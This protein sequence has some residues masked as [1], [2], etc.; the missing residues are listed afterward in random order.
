MIKKILSAFLS[1]AVIAA[2]I[3]AYVVTRPEQEYYTV[4]A[5][6]E[7]APNLFAGGRVMVRG[8]EVG[9]ITDVTPRP[10]GVRVTMKIEEGTKLPADAHLA[11]VPITVISDRY[12]QFSPAYSSG[13]LLE[14]G[15]HLAA[16]NTSIPAELD[17]V[18]K[19]LKQLLAT[20][21][22]KEGER[23]PLAKLI[24]DV[25]YIVR[26]KVGDLRGSIRNSAS[27]LENLASSSEDISGVIRNLDELFITLAER[28]SDIGLVNERFALVAEALARD[29]QSLEGTI[30]NVTLLSDEARRLFRES[31]DD[32]GEALLRTE[33]VVSG[34]LEHQ[35]AIADGFRWTNVIAQALGATDASGRGL[36]AYSG[37]QAAPG[38]PGAEYNYRLDTRDTITCE[39][40]DALAASLLS[41]GFG[42]EPEIIFGAILAFTPEEYHEDLAY[43]FRQL[44]PPCTGIEFDD[45]TTTASLTTRADKAVKKAVARVGKEEFRAAVGVW[46]LETIADGQLRDGRRR[47]S[48]QPRRN[49][50]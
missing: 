35:D 41:G 50:R 29:R 11:V 44:M 47:A 43:L 9:E 37:R 25:D 34:I 12:V 24:R 42:N 49:Q 48:E 21:E 16:S 3:Y 45:A 17:D 26:G 32:L 14:D 40:L 38:T 15:D 18:L 20:I 1:F 2:G 8:V 4:S 30:E 13:P 7:Q 36:Y 5:D 33:S 39:R 6:I 27:F 19:Q 10:N 31:G 28:R 23:G 22:P 46:L